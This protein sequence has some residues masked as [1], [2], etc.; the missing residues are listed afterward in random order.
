MHVIERGTFRLNPSAC[1]LYLAV[2]II[3]SIEN[4]KVNLFVGF[5]FNHIK[6][7]NNLLDAFIRKGPSTIL[8]ISI[9][10]WLKLQAGSFYIAFNLYCPE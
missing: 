5:P 7:Q 10:I 4:S 3:H 2:F 6:A 1:Q 8:R 9:K